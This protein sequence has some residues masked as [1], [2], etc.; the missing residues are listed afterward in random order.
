MTFLFCDILIIGVIIMTI[1]ELA[2]LDN[3]FNQ[4]MFI[5]KVNNIFIK[6]F[7]A[8]MTDKLDDVDHF[9]DDDVYNYGES[10]V[11][12]LRSKNYR[13]MYDELNVKESK[14]NSIEIIDNNYVIKVYL[15][16]RYMDYVIDLNTGNVV[17]GND[18]SRIQVNYLLTFTKKINATSQGIA[19]KCQ[20]CGAPMD[21]NNSGKCNY[22]G[23]IYKQED[24]DWVLTEL[25]II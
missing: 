4:A 21:V 23:S 15:E 2:N 14:I 5:T 17:S 25:N 1:Q 24:H 3:T 9:I 16:A 20:A 8:I 11:A 10:K 18:S 6:F 19:K 22:C 13:Q 12:P 7:T